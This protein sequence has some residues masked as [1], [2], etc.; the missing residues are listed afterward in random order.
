MFIILYLLKKVKFN[1]E[2]SDI[3]RLLDELA[4]LMCKKLTLVTVLTS[5]KKQ[6]VVD[7]YR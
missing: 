2:K 6:E 7:K 3:C 1:W 5:V 4:S